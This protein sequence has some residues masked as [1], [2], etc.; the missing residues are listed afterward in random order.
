MNIM[1]KLFGFEIFHFHLD[2]GGQPSMHA[3]E[4][5]PIEEFMPDGW[6]LEE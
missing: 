4:F 6:E 2:G 3:V 5:V 1:L